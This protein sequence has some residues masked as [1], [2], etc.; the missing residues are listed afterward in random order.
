MRIRNSKSFK[1]E[2]LIHVKKN[3]DALRLSL[4]KSKIICIKRRCLM[5][6]IFVLLLTLTAL[7][8]QATA[9]VEA[10]YTSKRYTFHVSV[11]KCEEVVKND[12]GVKGYLTMLQMN[13]WHITPNGLWYFTHDGKSGT[14]SYKNEAGYTMEVGYKYFNFEDTERL[15][16]ETRIIDPN[17]KQVFVGLSS[18]VVGAE[19]LTVVGSCES[20]EDVGTYR[21]WIT[22][23]IAPVTK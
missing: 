22:A 10:N 14:N 3:I 6:K 19:H 1:N 12:E 18:L 5:K 8:T 13:D 4:N 7:S 21:V 20:Q 9:E 17:N 11:A 16:V 2:F 23:E 15:V